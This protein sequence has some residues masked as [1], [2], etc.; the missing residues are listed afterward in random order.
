MRIAE[1]DVDVTYNDDKT[2][3]VTVTKKEVL[4]DGFYGEFTT[5]TETGTGTVGELTAK[6]VAENL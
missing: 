3:T 4:S 6:I 1:F 5:F 2:T